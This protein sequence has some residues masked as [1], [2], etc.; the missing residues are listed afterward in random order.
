MWN[1]FVVWTKLLNFLFLFWCYCKY[2]LKYWCIL[3]ID[4]LL[5]DTTDTELT[6]FCAA[7]N[8]LLGSVNTVVSGPF[9]GKIWIFYIL[10]T[11]VVWIL[12]ELCA[13]IPC[14]KYLLLSKL[15]S[16]AGELFLNIFCRGG[17]ST[18]TS[19]DFREDFNRNWEIRFT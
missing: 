2:F 9:S 1:V 8:V 18:Y 7:M 3:N 12:L 5:L 10:V 13:W 11:N 17:W 19:K 4:V 14:I 6:W 16:V 15:H